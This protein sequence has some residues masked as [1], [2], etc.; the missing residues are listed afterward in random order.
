MSTTCNIA[1]GYI[2]AF[3]GVFSPF[4]HAFSNLKVTNSSWKVCRKTNWS[5]LQ[6]NKHIN[7][8][9]HQH[10]LLTFLQ[11]NCAEAIAKG[12]AKKSLF[13]RLR[14]TQQLH[15]ILLQQ[16]HCERLSSILRGEK[17]ITSVE[18]TWKNCK[19]FRFLSIA[20]VFN[21]RKCIRTK[22]KRSFLCDFF[23][24]WTQ[25]Q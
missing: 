3:Y 20:K 8:P 11:S 19:T 10:R 12:G 23:R 5:A 25:N 17:K 1:N 6:Y 24:C 4:N 7:V 15:L 21:K 13:T 14:S 16:E 9:L 22:K 18:K 2:Y